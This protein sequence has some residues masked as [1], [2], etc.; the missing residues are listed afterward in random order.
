MGIQLILDD[1]TSDSIVFAFTGNLERKSLKPEA[2]GAAEYLI[3][4]R[5]ENKKI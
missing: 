3:N 5:V 2:L 4:Y 1:T